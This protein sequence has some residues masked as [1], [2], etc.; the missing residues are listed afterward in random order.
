[1]DCQVASFHREALLAAS[2]LIDLTKS[3]VRKPSVVFRVTMFLRDI[4]S[5]ATIAAFFCFNS[6]VITPVD[7][8]SS[9]IT[10]YDSLAL[11]Q[12]QTANCS[13]QGTCLS[14]SN[15]SC[16]SCSCTGQYVGN[17][18]QT[19]DISVQF[20]LLLWTSILLVVALIASVSLLAYMDPTKDSLVY[21]IGNQR[22]KID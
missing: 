9:N 8:Q 7:A 5:I 2:T 16:F 14:S 17:S 18:C 3:V 11:C 10:C 12:S 19:Y 21:R 1:M 20:H 4:L 13:S 6:F 15:G 22:P